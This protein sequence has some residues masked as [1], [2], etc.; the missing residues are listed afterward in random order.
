MEVS[1]KHNLYRTLALCAALLLGACASTPDGHTML[2]I[3]KA[4]DLET[5]A[6]C[7]AFG[8]LEDKML[9]VPTAKIRFDVEVVSGAQIA[10]Q[11]S[12]SQ[13]N[14]AVW[15]CYHQ[16]TGKAYMVGKDWRVYW[17]EWCHAK[18]GPAHVSVAASARQAR[19]YMHYI[20]SNSA[21]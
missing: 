3:S 18:F 10:Q 13:E 19:S 15:G 5:G 14:G 2:A 21:P 7:N 1:I 11:C 16:D 4:P 6:G 9:A 12:A 20:A 17:H 8:V